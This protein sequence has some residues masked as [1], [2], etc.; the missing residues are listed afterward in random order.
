MSKFVHL[1]ITKMAE[2]M[3]YP[4]GACKPVHYKICN[5]TN[6]FLN[7]GNYCKWKKQ[8]YSIFAQKMA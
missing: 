2:T 1:N 3:Q 6:F 4:P 7:T 8:E 5:I